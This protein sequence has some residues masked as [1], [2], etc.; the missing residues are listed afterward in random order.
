MCN[1]RVFSRQVLCNDIWDSNNCALFSIPVI[2]DVTLCYWAINSRRF[3]STTFLRIV[4]NY[5]SKD[6][7][8][9]L[10]RVKFIKLYIISHAKRELTDIYWNAL[11]WNKHEQWKLTTELVLI[12]TS[13]R[14]ELL[15]VKLH[16]EQC[17][18]SRNP[19]C[20]FDTTF[21]LVNSAYCE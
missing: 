12:Y 16:D 6:A 20:Y 5:T 11:W 7:E 4:G 3:E 1:Q 14:S 17:E 2:W 13:K 15:K 10:W 8:S 9:D 19:M 21:E 18:W